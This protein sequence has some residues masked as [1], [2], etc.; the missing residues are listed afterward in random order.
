[1]TLEITMKMIKA[2]KEKMKI[3][4]KETE[5]E[6]NQKLTKINKFLKENQE[7]QTKHNQTQTTEIL[8]VESLGKQTETIDANFH[9][10]TIRYRRENLRH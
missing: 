4:L 1:M 2:L 5:E 9:Q 10:Q 8:Q 7:K 3:S 6:G